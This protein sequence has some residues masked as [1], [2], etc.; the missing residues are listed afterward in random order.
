MTDLTTT[1]IPRQGRT[2]D[3]LDDADRYLRFDELQHTMAG[4]WESMRL[5]FRDESV[6]VVPSVSLQHSTATGP[7]LVQAMEERALFFL[8]LLR[9]PHLQMVYVTSMP[10]HDSVVEYSLGLL[11]GV[12][13]RHARARLHLLSVG[14]SGPQPLSAK[15]LARPRLLRRIR[16][17][18]PNAAHAH[19]IPY[20]TTTLERDIAISLGIPMYGADP[21]LEPLGSKSGCRRIFEDTG[22]PHPL[23]AEDL[24]TVAD[25]VEAVCR[26]R[27]RSPGITAAIAKFNDGVSGAGNASISLEGLPAPGQPGEVERGAQV[28]GL[29]ARRIGPH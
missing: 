25:V 18:V 14:D 24:H 2:L 12:I 4:V 27:A 11:P 8:L 28:L 23:G 20:N 16:E 19:L 6:V 22:V 3:Q 10:V 1:S 5:D 17:L 15:L 26:M 9:Q 7:A 13:P 29:V 21:R